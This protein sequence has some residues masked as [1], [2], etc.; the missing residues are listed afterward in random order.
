MTEIGF[1][2]KCKTC[3]A[4]FETEVTDIEADAQAAF[5]WAYA[6]T[7]G[8]GDDLNSVCRGAAVIVTPSDGYGDEPRILIESPWASEHRIE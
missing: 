2:A 3:S 5:R 6:H 1:Q 4:V 7:R 8:G